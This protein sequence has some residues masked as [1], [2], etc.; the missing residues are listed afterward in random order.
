MPQQRLLYLCFFLSGA[1]GLLYEIYWAQRFALLLGLDVYSHAAVLTAFMGG[2]ALGSYLAGRRGDLLSRPWAAYAFLELGIA[3]CG[4]FIPTVLALLAYPLRAVYAAT[5]AA[6]WPVTLVRF[7]LAVAV[8]LVPTMLMGATLPVMAVALRRG[9]DRLGVVVGR[10]YA[11]NTAGAVIGVLAGGFVLGEVLGLA[12]TNLTAAGLNVAAAL[13][14]LWIG[15]GAA[16]AAQAPVEASVAVSY[17]PLD[18]SPVDPESPAHFSGLRIG[19][20]AESDV[21]PDAHG[22]WI[23]I[24]AGLTGA[25]GMMNQ[26]GWTRIIAFNLGSSTYAFST[27]VAVFLV[28]LAVGATLA[29][30]LMKRWRFAAQ[31]WAYACLITAALSWAVMLPLGRSP[32]DTAELLRYL[33]VDQ[34][35]SAG[36]IFTVGGLATFGLFALPTIALGMTLPLACEA[37]AQSRPGGTARTTG[38]VYAM[39]TVG[40]MLGSAAGGLW[41]LDRLEVQGLLH[42]A[43]GTYAL[44]GLIAAALAWRTPPEL[45]RPAV[46]AIGA[47]AGLCYLVFAVPWDRQAFLFGPFLLT[48]VTDPPV[49]VYHHQGAYGTVAVVREPSRT[50]GARPNTALIVDGKPD[51]S[52]TFD[53]G[54]QWFSGH[55]PLLLHGHAKDVALIG[56]G[57]GGTLG[58]SL[59]HPIDR[60]DLIELSH[61]VLAAIQP[62]DGSPGPFDHING[63]GLKDPRTRTIVADGRNHLALTDDAYDVIISEPSNPWMAGVSYL[64]TREH[65]LGCRARLKPGGILCQWLHAYSLSPREFFRVLQTVDAVFEHTTVWASPSRDDYFF[66]ACKEP[67]DA[68]ERVA[69]LMR[70][71]TIKAQLDALQIRSEADFWG[72]F[73]FKAADLRG[74]DLGAAIGV[75]GE[76]APNTDN[77]NYLNYAAVRNYWKPSDMDFYEVLFRNASLPEDWA[78]AL[79]RNPARELEVRRIIDVQDGYRVMDW[80]EDDR[81]VYFALAIRALGVAPLSYVLEVRDVIEDEERLARIRSDAPEAAL[82]RANAEALLAE[83]KSMSDGPERRQRAREGRLYALVA[84]E[85]H[86]DNAAALLLLTE[87]QLLLD[88]PDEA[89]AT[90]DRAAERGAEIPADLR[91]RVVDALAAG[92]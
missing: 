59:C 33:V 71:P 20:A 19:I 86:S 41:L 77:R 4:L 10:L 91:A 79:L 57:G 5:D 9:G 16:Q 82:F 17:D 67:H 80:Y 49:I 60:V 47:G 73:L 62:P 1:A 65:F 39:N 76:L 24:G 36:W 11:I 44:V 53:M 83:A 30:W 63:R 22:R 6:F 45:F 12:G 66:I 2:L 14:A 92:G 85:A 89:K 48:R 68:T 21:R 52:D 3:A 27:I 84:V 31:P 72:T 26:I 28:G 78:G 58:A 46:C 37:Y 8:L 43:A 29:S 7:G 75:F 38:A 90:L 34:K 42:V 81:K 32:S 35:A 55:L 88:R 13:L 54:T 50:P 25:A 56:L 74:R 51:A 70:V 40:A 18:L 61:S 15:R 64:F 69:D 87:A 23:A